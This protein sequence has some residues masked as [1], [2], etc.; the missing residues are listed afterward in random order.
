MEIRKVKR[1]I[2]LLEESNIAELE[3]TEGD[4]SVRISRYGSAPPPVHYQSAPAAP[5]MAEVV[6][7]AERANGSAEPAPPELPPGHAVES[8]MVGTAYRSPSPDAQ[9]FVEVGQQVAAGDTICIIEAMKIL[10][11]IEA[12][13]SGTVKAILFENAQPVE[14]GQP[15][16][17][18]EP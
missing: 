17:L 12:D 18:I 9:P 6:H 13:V 10:N 1:L 5:P 16:M 7:S 3:I 11:Q 14:F 4:Q 15:L 8:P 2:E